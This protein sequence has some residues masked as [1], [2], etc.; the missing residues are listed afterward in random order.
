MSRRAVW[1][2]A[3]LVLLG[4]VAVSGFTRRHRAAP[5]SA[6]AASNEAQVRDLDIAFYRAR[7]TRDPEG[8]LDLARLAG[9]YLQRSRETGNGEDLARAEAA[10]AL[11]LA[12]RATRNA[13]ALQ[14]VA[15]SQLAQHK[16]IQA[17]G[18]ATRLTALDPD[19]RAFQAMLAETQMELGRYAEAG[20]GFDRLASHSSDL[21]VG[22]RLAR[23]R[24][25][26]G[27][28][29][30]AHRLLVAA[31]DAA[32]QLAALPREQLAW[33]QLRLGE[34]ALRYG[35]LGEAEDAF[36]GGLEASP[37]DY[38]L[39]AAMARLHADRHAWTKTIEFGEQ[40]IETALDPATLGLV[41]DAY[42][43]RGDSAKA[44]EYYRAMEVT[45]LKQPGA[46]HRAWSLFLLDHD[47]DLAPVLA[48][49]EEE[50]ETRQDIYG[51]DLLAWAR[52]KAGRHG[53][54]WSAMEQALALGTQDAGLFF[55]AGMIQRALGRRTEA[56]NYLALALEVNRSFDPSHPA[57]ARAV[58]D[59]LRRERD[60]RSVALAR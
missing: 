26:Q 46:F 43:A 32:S 50:I 4:G 35:R 11:S 16:F 39:L 59:S 21:S 28:P 15:A 13:A 42:A 38:R 55:H 37:T 53:E 7:A 57:V 12:H 20:A 19:Q 27:K 8:A 2:I 36:E 24:E 25:L 40:A 47:R 14:L 1:L 10:A 17:L 29:E 41:G 51:Y 22:P 3:L 18:A 58:L 48:K 45:V 44:E 9:L 30:E 5:A 54:A 31:R 56:R 34:L 52:F 6:R 33:F 60:R 23:W 49:A